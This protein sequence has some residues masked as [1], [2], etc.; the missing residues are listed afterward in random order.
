MTT[1]NAKEKFYFLINRINDAEYLTPSGNQ[2]RIHPTETLNNKFS[3]QEL[4]GVMKKLSDDLGI[5][6][7]SSYPTHEPGIV[8]LDDEDNCYFL[9]VTPKFQKYKE[10]LE[11]DP[12]YRT[13]TYGH[14]GKAQKEAG[15]PSQSHNEKTKTPTEV[16]TPKFNKKYNAIVFM[17]E[18]I[19]I[20]K[21]S[22]QSELCNVLF[23]TKK[24]M[25][26]EWDFDTICEKSD[27]NSVPDK[28]EIE[29]LYRAARAV[30]D[31][32]AK[33]TTVKDFLVI[34]KSTVLINPIY[35]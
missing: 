1:M 20:P 11:H 2:I 13:F 19:P 31:H 23:A 7:L 26:L 33:E 15:K 9:E 8:V 3:K 29:K 10:D 12:D 14:S 16:D 27:P 24:S 32:I 5:I 17:N 35:R 34:T 21:N 30:N 6:K 28:K 18:I 4:S 25:T 22:N